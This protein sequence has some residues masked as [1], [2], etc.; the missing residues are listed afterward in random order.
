MSMPLLS[1]IY[2][3]ALSMRPPLHP[4]LPYLSEQ[5]TRFCSERL[6]SFLALIK[7]WP[8]REPVCRNI[9]SQS[10]CQWNQG[11]ECKLH[12]YQHMRNCAIKIMTTSY[13]PRSWGKVTSHKQMISNSP[14]RRPSKSRRPLGPLQ[15]WRHPSCASLRSWEA[16][17]RYTGG[18]TWTGA[19]RST[20]TR[21]WLC[22]PPRWSKRYEK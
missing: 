14:Q 18:W 1:L 15:E 16:P 19:S 12:S 13:W 17:L 22:S 5:S 9:T 20:G 3:K 8:S 4:R 21:S 7:C 2:S 11:Q 10:F 6:T